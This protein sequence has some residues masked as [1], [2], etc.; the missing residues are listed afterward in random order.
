MEDTG[1]Q[2]ASR[3]TWGL[4]IGGTVVF[5]LILI[6]VVVS[7]KLNLTKLLDILSHAN[8]LLVL[9][10]I[11]LIVLFIGVKSGRWRAILQTYG[12]NLSLGQ[13]WR[14]YAIGLGA[15]Q[16]TP[17]QAGDVIKAWYLKAM[18]YPLSAALLSTVVD[19]LFDV[20]M[21]GLLTLEGV[22]VFW[23]SMSGDL[24]IVIALIVGSAIGLVALGIRPVRER[25]WQMVMSRLNKGKAADETAPAAEVLHHRRAFAIASLLTFA[26]FAV[27]ITRVWLLCFAVGLNIGP[28]QII[29]INALTTAAA[30]IPISVGGVGTRDAI[31]V[32]IF[33]LL[34]PNTNYAEYAVAVSTLILLLNIS[35]TVVGYAVWFRY[36]A[37]LEEVAA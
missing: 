4:R 34:F 25:L 32:F 22:I 17:G 11:S 2:P 14:I 5:V 27:S 33:G 8:W 36:P 18:G 24:P 7:N 15:G 9:L 31:L 26:S 10:S 35:N 21:L 16:F 37:K 13:A 19:R 3:L 6:Y 12:I 29:G 1:K 30:L 23:Q 20:V 28:L